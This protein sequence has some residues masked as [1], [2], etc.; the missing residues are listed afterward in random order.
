[1][2]YFIAS[3]TVRNPETLEVILSA[4]QVMTIPDLDAHCAEHGIDNVPG[5]LFP[6]FRVAKACAID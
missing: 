1:M 3:V 5:T 4:G 2:M 6:T